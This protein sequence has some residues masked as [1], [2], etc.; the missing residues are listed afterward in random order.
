MRLRLLV[1]SALGALLGC[2]F[3]IANVAAVTVRLLLVSEVVG[4]CV[5]LADEI[6]DLLLFK[7]RIAA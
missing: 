4:I 3:A 5:L 7:P 2:Q 6:A 1:C